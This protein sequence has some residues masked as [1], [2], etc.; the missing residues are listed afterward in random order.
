M[1]ETKT[2]IPAEAEKDAAADA[3]LAQ[4]VS[5]EKKK[6]RRKLVLAV[7]VL[8]AVVGWFV[9][10]PFFAA[11]REIDTG[12]RD[13][14]AERRDLTVSVSGSGA[15]QPADSYNIIALV[16]GDILSADF[17][18]GDYVS[19]DDLLF[20]IDPSDAQRSIEQ[21]E[22][23]LQNASLSYE[24]IVDSLDGLAPKANSAGRVAR[25]YV[26]AGD[27]VT[28]GMMLAEIRDS[29]TMVLSVPF[30][31][32]DAA[33]LTAGMA[34]QVTMADTGEQLAGTVSKVSGTAQVGSGGILTC[35]VEI[36]V[37]NPGGIAGGAAATASVGSTV[38]AGTGTFAEQAAST[39]YAG[40]AG[41]VGQVYVSEGQWVARDQ[42]L[43][44]I[45]SDSAQRQIESAS[46]NLRASEISLENARDILDNYTI[47]APISGTVV[48][49]N[50]KTGDT[51]DNTSASAL[52]VIY[53]MSY[54]TLTLNIDELYIRDIQVGQK[55]RIEADAVSEQT[56]E[57][58]ID[59]IGINGNVLS[60][61]TSYPVRVI[62]EE[63]GDLLPGMNVTAEIILEEAQNVLTVPVSA[64]SRGNT[65]LVADPESTGDA[66]NGIPAGYRQV[67]VEVGRSDDDYIEITSGLSEGDRVAVS[68]ATTSLFETMLNNGPMGGGQ[69]AP[70]GGERRGQ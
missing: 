35:T 44:T 23:S 11:K 1:A 26:E 56:F 9:V 13:F 41:T 66:E 38:C 50:Y 51:L 29:D 31:Q 58:Y 30:H 14:T 63:Y 43:L 40:A 33:G 61:V 21:A 62:L 6:K 60:G 32:S 34:A 8:A 57:G 53:D 12:Y 36:T 48:E 2:P 46:L 17:E 52:A 64:V 19:K 22:L 37:R 20:Q 54:L 15:L 55:V 70:G 49:K 24:N 27:E 42:S 45:D 25:L 39:V 28:A 47:T 16:Q 65:V 5:G 3:R 10:R 7:L 59:R 67:Q 18:E 4:M 68:T 69:G